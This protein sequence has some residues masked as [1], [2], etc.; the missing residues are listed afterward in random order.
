MKIHNNEYYMNKAINLAKKAYGRTNPNPIVGAIIVK[1]NQIIGTGYHEKAGTPHAEIHALKEAGT[2]AKDSTVYVTLEPCNHYGKTPPC[3]DALIQAGIKK[4]VIAS[5]DPNP[6]VAGKG[7]L[8]LKEA[9]ITIE[10][11][12]CKD[13]A[14]KMNQLFFKYIKTNMPYI[15]L[16]TAMTLDGKIATYT[17]DSKW[18]SNELSRNYVHELRNIYDG[19]LV[20]IGTVLKDNPS[21]NTRLDKNDIRNPVRII[22]DENLDIPINSNII[23]T[24]KEQRTII[25]TSKNTATK[26]INILESKGIEIEQTETDENNKLILEEVLNNLPK[27]GIYSVLIE[28][29]GEINGSFIEK[30]LIDKVY[31]FIAPKIVGGKHAPSPVS[32][33]GIELINQ[34]LYVERININK[35]ENDL[36]I[37]G[38]IRWW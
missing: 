17:G 22:I 12:M 1:K 38:Y 20:G 13:E 15:S 14:N 4:I 6:L 9:G 7:A 26:K 27:K 24:S 32:G 16:K 25:Y 10:I 8:K 29:G 28:G 31:W 23:N 11:G 33:Q 18:I 21:L 37:T 34:A 5:L 3:T 36:L 19:I 30:R 35:F 2:D